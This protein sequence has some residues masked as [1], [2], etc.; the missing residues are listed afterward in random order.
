MFFALTV[1]KVLFTPYYFGRTMPDNTIV[2][3]YFKTAAGLMEDPSDAKNKEFSWFSNGH[4]GFRHAN[5]N[6]SD[7]KV[8]SS[9][10]TISATVEEASS[11][12]ICS[13]CFN[14]ALVQMSSH[15]RNFIYFLDSYT[16][17]QTEVKRYTTNDVGSSTFNNLFTSLEKVKSLK[18][19][20]DRGSGF[21]EF[22]SDHPR[23][24]KKFDSLYDSFY[25]KVSVNLASRE[26][27]V[28]REVSFMSIDTIL[29]SGSEIV[30]NS[31]ILET[32]N[33]SGYYRNS[34]TVELYSA[35]RKARFSHDKAEYSDNLL[36]SV[37]SKFTLS[38][39][40]QLKHVK[41]NLKNIQQDSGDIS[42]SD[43]A[44]TSWRSA[45]DIAAKAAISEW[46]SKLADMLSNDARVLVVIHTRLTGYSGLPEIL[47]KLQATSSCADSVDGKIA[48]NLPKYAAEYISASSSFR[49]GRSNTH[50]QICEKIASKDVIET[51]LTLW[52]PSVHEGAY[53]HFSVCLDAAEA[54]V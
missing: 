35:W 52:D 17:L 45:R 32:L 28:L 1:K 29:N 44:E 50:I 51:A 5:K 27:D 23:A 54:L 43:L 36:E 7:L 30:S 9:L 22:K 16:K 42:L 40:K 37:Y 38:D 46:D 48:L 14:F 3:N 41:V 34:K 11:R 15:G 47:E 6:C 10:V 49:S 24:F 2:L 53:I 13:K 39:L 21:E 33:T 8:T 12:R 20:L 19:S 25:D 4:R 18:L 31:S 26:S